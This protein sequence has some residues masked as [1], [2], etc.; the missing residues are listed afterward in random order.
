MTVKFEVNMM[1]SIGEGDGDYEIL[2]VDEI[3]IDGSV[4]VLTASWPLSHP[5]SLLTSGI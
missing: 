5:E 3:F 4:G 2:E 1:Y